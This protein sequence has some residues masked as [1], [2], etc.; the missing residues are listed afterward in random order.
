MVFKMPAFSF[1]MILRLQGILPLNPQAFGGLPGPGLQYRGQFHYKYELAGLWRRIDDELS[2]ADDRSDRSEFCL[3]CIGD[4]DSRRP[5]P[6]LYE[7]SAN[8]IG[9]YWVDMTRSTF[10][11]FCRSQLI[12]AMVLVSQGVVQ[13][14]SAYKNVPLL[15]TITYDN[16]KSMTRAILLK[17]PAESRSRKSPLRSRSC[18]LDLQHL[19]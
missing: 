10:T 18:R 9:N 17:A 8:S 6:G 2:D 7:R 13:N 16:P 1:Y 3:C 12:M 14:F 15:Q 11:S 19:R 4:G 5:H